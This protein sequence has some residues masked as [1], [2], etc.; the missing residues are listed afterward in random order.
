VG[1]FVW[2]AATK[3]LSWDADGAGGNAAVKIATFTT[4]V[5]LTSADFLIL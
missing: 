2:D 3:T 1:Q 4:N 5:P